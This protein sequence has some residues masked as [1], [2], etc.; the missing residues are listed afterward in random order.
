VEERSRHRWR[1]WG[2]LLATALILTGVGAAGSA[3]A[4]QTITVEPDSPGAENAFPFGVGA[5]DWGPFMGFVYKNVPAFQMKSGD[6]LAFDLNQLNDADDQL[7]IALAQTTSNGNDEPSA[8]FTKIVSN[9]QVPANPRGDLADGTYELQY[10]AEASFDFP[11]GGLIIRFSNPG[12]E[13]AA[14]T[15]QDG[16]LHNGALSSD[17]SDQFV[18]RFLRDPDGA[19]PWTGDNVTNDIAAFRVQILDLPA[20]PPP[21]GTSPPAS[22][23]KKKCK[24]KHKK[25]SAGVAKKKCKKKKRR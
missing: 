22:T 4:A 15:V 1:I 25:H 16:V 24:K 6:V 14:D 20:T 17:P 2:A 9:T 21:T 8:G 10:K 13:L 5:D 3:Q 19:F 18:E 23:P 12:P 7:E 11:G